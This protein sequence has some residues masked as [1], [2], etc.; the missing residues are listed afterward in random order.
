M[1]KISEKDLLYFADELYRLAWMPNKADA[2]PLNSQLRQRAHNLQYESFSDRESLFKAIEY[3]E[4][5][6]GD[7]RRKEHWLRQ[8][9][10]VW[11]VLESRL[12]EQIASANTRNAARELTRTE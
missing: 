5:A 4:A 1:S 6:S 7:A 2:N 8:L 9:D 12:M 10:A 11:I 3:A